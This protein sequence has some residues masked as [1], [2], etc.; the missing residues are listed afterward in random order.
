MDTTTKVTGILSKYMRDPV[1]A[2]ESATTLDELEIDRLDLH[3]I[4]LD[5]EDTFDVHI[6]YEDEIEFFTSVGTLVACVTS[7]LEAKS[8]PRLRAPRI[9][10]SWL[11]TTA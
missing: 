6:G 10:R 5:I 7:H 2:I 11:S 9:K 3:M 8:K 4:F 1:A